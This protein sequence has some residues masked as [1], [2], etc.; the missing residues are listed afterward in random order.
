MCV[1]EVLLSELV[2]ETEN[3]YYKGHLESSLHPPFKVLCTVG[4]HMFCEN[5]TLFTAK[6]NFNE[7]IYFLLV[8]I[9]KLHLISKIQTTRY[10]MYLAKKVPGLTN[11]TC[12]QAQTF[13]L[14]RKLYVGVEHNEWF[15]C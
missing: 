11:L 9:N 3:N 10:Y 1:L 5:I 7:T 14:I 12:S 15:H 13:F 6:F 2:S 4:S 8:A